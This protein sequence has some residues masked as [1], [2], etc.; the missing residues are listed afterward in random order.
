M[1]K[2]RWMMVVALLLLGH[3][4]AQAAPW[5]GLF[6]A[7][8]NRV[9]ADPDRQ[10]KLSEDHGPWLILAATMTG[11][12]ADVQAQ[13]LCVELRKRYKLQAFT[14]DRLFDFTGTVVGR[15]VN[16]FGD[17][18]R[19]RYIRSK[20]VQEVA[21]MIGHFASVDDPD[22]QKTL[23]LVKKLRPECLEEE[24]EKKSL[25]TSDGDISLAGYRD[26]IREAADKKIAGRFKFI[27][28]KEG[29]GR[30]ANAFLVPNPMLSSE[31]IRRRTIDPFV[32]QLNQ[33]LE[34]SLFNCPG[35]HS[36]IVGTFR[37]YSS[38]NQEQILEQDEQA[39]VNLASSRLAEAADNAHRLT[40]ALREK[41]YE[42][43]EFH[44]RQQ[45]VVCIGSFDW[46]GTRQPDGKININPKVQRVMD[47]FGAGRAQQLA[48]P[49][50]VRPA[51]GQP[52]VLLGLPLDVMPTPIEV[53]RRP[54]SMD[55]EQSLLG[56]R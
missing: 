45:S 49:G 35:K 12:Q 38:V 40:L 11:E 44:D 29:L 6:A 39:K 2:P 15:G 4:S 46:V 18:K 22:A 27:N 25:F 54:I 36:V 43:Y 8:G 50:S 52:K 51:T 20:K 28:R 47:T 10:Y 24:E 13:A 48:V 42:A 31:E 30:L 7:K 37:G 1:N 3:V 16:K 32:V 23:A 53:P 14:H 9:E 41:G 33:E 56:R 26:R 17:P 55:Y 21:V 5:E 34:F 19:M